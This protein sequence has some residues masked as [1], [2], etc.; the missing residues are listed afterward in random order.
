[1]IRFVDIRCAET[2]YKFAFWDTVTDK[3]FCYCDEQAWGT[4]EEFEDAAVHDEHPA[5]NALLDR[6]E[7]LCP[8]WLIAPDGKGETNG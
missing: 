5:D 7:A 2:G 1:M 4:W 3:F 8:E 6:F